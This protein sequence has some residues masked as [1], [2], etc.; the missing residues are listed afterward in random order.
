MMSD[1]PPTY[2]IQVKGQ[3]GTQWGDW[4]DNATITH[5]ADGFTWMTCTV[6]D[7]AA[8]Y[9]VLRQIRD[10]GLTLISVHRLESD[11]DDLSYP[12]S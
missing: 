10:L 3:L 2:E 4:F 7:Q 6:E 1:T 9:G 8:L 5:S 12:K 11:P